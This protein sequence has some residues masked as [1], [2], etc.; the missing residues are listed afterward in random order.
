MRT[1]RARRTRGGASPWVPVAI[2]SRCVSSAERQSSS[3]SLSWSQSGPLPVPGFGFVRTDELAYR[4]GV[5]VQKAR[6]RVRRLVD[7]GLLRRARA[8]YGT[9]LLSVTPRGARALRLPGTFKR[10]RV[11]WSIERDLAIVSFVAG[12]ELRAPHVDVMT[13]RELKHRGTEGWPPYA[14]TLGGRDEP[15][16]RRW[17]D[18]AVRTAR[19]LVAVEWHFIAKRE[20]SFERIVAGYLGGPYD[21]VRFIVTDGTTGAAPRT[22]DR[23]APLCHLLRGRPPRSH[24]RRALGPARP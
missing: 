14:I 4:F 2:G 24:R 7:A 8:G 21:E 22:A 19:G 9:V 18:V 17:P 15:R 11:G 13:R 5:S 1:D 10:P 6:R 23:P 12:V 20:R 3:G 16:G